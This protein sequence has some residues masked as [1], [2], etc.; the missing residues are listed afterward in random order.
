MKFQNQHFT[1]WK[2]AHEFK[3][4]VAVKVCENILKHMNYLEETFAK[5][6]VR[7]GYGNVN[8]ENIRKWYYDRN[9]YIER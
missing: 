9:I 7:L 6:S 2:E 3:G 5:A 4:A 8:N 1:S